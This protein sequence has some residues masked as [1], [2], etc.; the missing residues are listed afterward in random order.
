MRPLASGPIACMSV[1][2][3]LLNSPAL[4]FLLFV[5]LFILQGER[6]Q[7]YLLL[8]LSCFIFYAFEAN[9]SSFRILALNCPSVG[10][11]L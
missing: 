2:S 8:L 10:E 11:Y 5:L 1:V 4:S 3:N 7:S 9:P 6:V